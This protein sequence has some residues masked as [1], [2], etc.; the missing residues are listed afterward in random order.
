[1]FKEQEYHAI[2]LKKQP[3]GEA[4]EIITFFTKENGKVRGLAKSVKQPKSKLQ[5]ALQSLFFIKLTLAARRTSGLRKIIRAEVLDSFSRAHEHLPI[6]KAA[7]YVLEII[8]KGT[9]D[10]HKNEKLFKLLLDFLQFCSQPHLTPRTLAA[11]LLKFQIW[12]LEFSGLAIHYPKASPQPIKIYFSNRHGGFF[13]NQ[14]FSDS[15]PV[16]KTVF[17][18]FAA[19]KNLSFAQ[20]KGFKGETGYLY[21]LLSN[22]LE[23]QLERE[24]KAGKYLNE[25]V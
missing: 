12:F 21:A 15:Q 16:E 24:I 2:I 22:F 10:E 8:I 5:H 11:G 19:L 23:Y 7:W 14:I 17:D 3:F 4:D 6:A 25:Q 13:A 18:H 9:A 20:L 1:M